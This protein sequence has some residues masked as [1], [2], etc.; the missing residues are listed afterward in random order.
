MTIQATTQLFAFRLFL[1]AICIV[2]AQF[3]HIPRVEIFSL[4]AYRIRFPC[5]CL[6]WIVLLRDYT[7][8][9]NSRWVDVCFFLSNNSMVK[10]ILLHVSSLRLQRCFLLPYFRLLQ[11]GKEDTN[12][13]LHF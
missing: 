6:E 5:N 7:D 1:I 11:V 9:S 4:C 3:A 8:V 2:Q 13:L 12:V 10:C